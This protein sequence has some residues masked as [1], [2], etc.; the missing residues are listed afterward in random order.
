MT[1]M[2]RIEDTN[3]MM[4]VVATTTP[5]NSMMMMMM[6]MMLVLDSHNPDKTLHYHS[7]I[8]FCPV[9]KVPP[10]VAVEPPVTP[11]LVKP[12]V[13]PEKVSWRHPTN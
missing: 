4:L 11:P 6:M 7:P 2:A 3:N 8:C 1:R 13:V 12:P 9:L 5:I 10:H